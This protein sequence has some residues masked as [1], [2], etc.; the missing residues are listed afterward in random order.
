MNGRVVNG[1]YI[2]SESEQ[3]ESDSQGTTQRV[4]DWMYDPHNN[5]ISHGEH[6][7]SVIP[8]HTEGMENSP[9]RHLSANSS[10]PGSPLAGGVAMTVPVYMHQQPESDSEARRFLSI[11][12]IIN[13]YVHKES[14]D[15][16]FTLFLLVFLRPSQLPRCDWTERT[17]PQSQPC[18]KGGRQLTGMG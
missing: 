16:F 1:R 5:A 7:L 10:P 17:L 9:P 14:L 18:G 12:L 11:N 6:R 15:G 2:S 3:S 13:N 4:D 8:E